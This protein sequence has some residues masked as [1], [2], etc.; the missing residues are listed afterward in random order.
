MER[1]KINEN[2]LHGKALYDMTEHRLY[3][4]WFSSDGEKTAIEVYDMPHYNKKMM[5]VL[6]KEFGKD[7]LRLEAPLSAYITTRKY[8]WINGTD[9]PE[10]Y[11]EFVESNDAHESFVDTLIRSSGYEY[12]NQIEAF[13]DA[14]VSEKTYVN[15]YYETVKELQWQSE[16]F[17]KSPILAALVEAGEWVINEE[18]FKAFQTLEEPCSIAQICS[19]RYGSEEFDIGAFVRGDD[20]TIDYFRCVSCIDIDAVEPKNFIADYVDKNPYVHTPFEKVEDGLTPVVIVD[21]D[22]PESFKK[23]IVKLLL[24]DEQIEF[25]PEKYQRINDEGTHFWPQVKK[26]FE[27]F[28]AIEAKKDKL[29]PKEITTVAEMYLNFNFSKEDVPGSVEKIYTKMEQAGFNNPRKM[30]FFENMASK[31]NYSPENAEVFKKS[32]TELMNQAITKGYKQEVDR[33]ETSPRTK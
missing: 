28:T 31:L 5:E 27:E 30:L 14:L 12:E 13:F 24:R 8:R 11:Y 3:K 21:K 9:F 23:S 22:S 17:D 29:S 33:K 32:F 2:L 20:F 15:T 1:E 25:A 7:V 6:F 4:P 16:E 19:V 26:K 10:L 18:K